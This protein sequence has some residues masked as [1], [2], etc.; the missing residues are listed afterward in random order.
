MVSLNAENGTYT[1]CENK[2][3]FCCVLPEVFNIQLCFRGVLG[4]HYKENS[5]LLFCSKIHC[6]ELC[7]FL[8]LKE[9]WVF[10]FGQTF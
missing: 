8:K 4:Q 9:F 3:H 10:L 1:V 2:P 6:I 5:E 7:V